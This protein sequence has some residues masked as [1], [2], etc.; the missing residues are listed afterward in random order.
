[1]SGLVSGQVLHLGR[2]ASPQF[3]GDGIRLRLIRVH[4]WVTN[5]AEWVWLEGYQLDDDGLATD[6]RSVYV[7][8]AGVRHA[9]S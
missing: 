9:A 3:T 2:S 7:R 6:L 8:L 5:D 4:G 1:M